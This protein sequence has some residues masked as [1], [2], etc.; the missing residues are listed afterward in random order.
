M[1]K[2]H[3]VITAVVTFYVTALLFLIIGAR[4]LWGGVLFGDSF[5]SKIEKIDYLLENKYIFDYDDQKLKESALE[6]YLKA[7]GDVYTEYISKAEFSSYKASS[8]GKYKGIGV[9]VSLNGDDVTIVTVNPLTPAEKAGIQPG[10]IIRKVNGVEVNAESYNDAISIIRGSDARGKD[11][12]LSLV[13]SRSGEEISLNI[14]REE[15]ESI[16]VE[17]KIL[18]GNIG[19]IKISSFEGTTGEQFDKAVEELQKSNI[20]GMIFDVRN[21]P[22]GTLESVLSVTNR[23][24]KDGVIL[25]IKDKS[26]HEE[27]F[28]ADGDESIMLPVCVI[29][30]ANSASAAEVFSAALKENGVASLVGETTFGKGIVQSIFELDDETAVK[31]TTAKYYTPDGT[32]IHDMGIKPD[33]EVKLHDK[34]KNKSISDVPFAH[35]LQLKKA[36]EVIIEKQK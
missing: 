12:N 5:S 24:L 16:T 20:K 11:D 4:L 18:N 25:T 34:Y 7:C 28:K 35:D 10:D 33:Y 14:I 17:K 21:N 29:A 31:L 27:V 36:I 19:Y 26:G 3:I 13:V 22:G 6:S 15:V 23:V 8:E 2:R 1:K 30:N 9:V 32:C